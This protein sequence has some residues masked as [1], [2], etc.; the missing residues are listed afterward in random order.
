MFNWQFHLTF[1][2]RENKSPQFQTFETASKKRKRFNNP[3]WLNN[4]PAILA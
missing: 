4:E 2:N 1:C 3:E